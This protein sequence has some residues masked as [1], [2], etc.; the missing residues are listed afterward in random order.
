M[1]R[2][3]AT[4]VQQAGWHVF[5]PDGEGKVVIK[6]EPYNFFREVIR[7]KQIGVTMSELSLRL[8]DGILTGFCRNPHLSAADTT[9]VR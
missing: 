9:P 8:S 3:R 6:E 7:H 2:D 5:S 1:A 4:G